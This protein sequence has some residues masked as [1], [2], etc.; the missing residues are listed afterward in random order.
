[1]PGGETANAAA[2]YGFGG[3]PCVLLD[4]LNEASRPGDPVFFGI[5]TEIRRRFGVCNPGA[6]T[7]VRDNTLCMMPWTQACGAPCHDIGI[8]TSNTPDAALGTGTAI[9]RYVSSL[10][11][12]PALIGC[13]HTA[14]FAGVMGTLQGGARPLT[15]LYFDAHYDLGLHA[16]DANLHNG[17]FVSRLL[18]LEQVTGVVNVGARSWAVHVP[19]YRDVPRFTWIPGGV[20]Q[21]S[22]AEMIDRLGWLRGARLYVSI[23]ADVLD[24]SSAPNVPCPEPFGMPPGDLFAIC[25][26]LGRSCDVVGGDLCEI[27]PSPHSLTSEQVLMR[28]FHALFGGRR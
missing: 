3:A 26:W 18:G 25:R 22:A 20:P 13:D 19:V 1:M 21:L 23:D 28:C 6:A 8:V 9:A 24:P 5:D 27:L 11:R 14:S 4:G 7:F 16:P 15:Y 17:N 12:R 2:C 10:G